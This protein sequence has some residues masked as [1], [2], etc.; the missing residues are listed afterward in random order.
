MSQQSQQAQQGVPTQHV[1]PQETPQQ[2]MPP[3]PQQQMPQQQTQQPQATPMWQAPAEAR[4]GSGGWAMVGS[5]V[6]GLML[7]MLGAM[8]VFMGI[9]AMSKGSFYATVDNELVQINTTGWGWIHLVTGGLLVLSGFGV[10]A[11]WVWATVTAI[12]LAMFSAIDNFLFLP[13]YPL[14]SLVIIALDILV[15]WALVTR[16]S[17]S[18]ESMR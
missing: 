6:G 3:P 17:R 13:H 9:V 8:Q 10:L 4:S 12:V 18:A 14:W 16:L 15:I 11:G 2:Q 7:I 5:V 1:P